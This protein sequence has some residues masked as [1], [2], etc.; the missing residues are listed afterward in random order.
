[1]TGGLSSTHAW[2]IYARKKHIVT[3]EF[4]LLSQ[5]NYYFTTVEV[6]KDVWG[7]A[8]ISLAFVIDIRLFQNKVHRRGAEA[9]ERR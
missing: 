5:I 8:L 9:A 7:I 1:V 6:E 3:K 2:I 4:F